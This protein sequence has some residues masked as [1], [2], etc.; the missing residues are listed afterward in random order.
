MIQVNT[1]NIASFVPEDYF[2]AREGALEQAQTWLQEATGAGNDFVGW[3]HL[4]RDYDKEE[5]ARIK[6][7]AKK[8]VDDNWSRYSPVPGYPAL[9]NAICE[10]L[11]RENGLEYEPSQIVVGNGA[12]QA[13][14]IKFSKKKEK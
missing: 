14:K 9:R 12:K 8:A 11:R 7:A 13:L 2:A 10:K 5:F 6:A 3:V 1:K 4:P